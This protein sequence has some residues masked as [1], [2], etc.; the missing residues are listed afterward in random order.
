VRWVT[1]LLVLALVAGGVAAYRLDL[2]VPWYD[3]FFGDEPAAP[4]AESPVEVPPP[5]ALDL[6]PV[7]ATVP[8]AEVLGTSG[9]AAPAQVEAALAPYLAD[10]DLGPHVLAAVA[11]RATGR[12]LARIGSGDAIPASTTKLL[13]GLAA[14][15]ALGPERTFSTRV[16]AGGRGRV[17][18]VGGGDPFLMAE[19]VG[20]DGPSYPARADVVTLADKTAA[21]LRRQGRTKVRLGFDDSLFADPGFNPA[22]P[23]SY[24]E[25]G[26][27]VSPITALWV[28]Q[29]REPD[30]FRRVED[31][32]L[33]GAQVFAA[34]LVEAG[35]T[36]VGDPVHGVAGGSGREIASVTSAPVREIVERVVEVSDNEAAEVLAHHIG[37]E[38]RGAGSFSAGVEGT[39]RTL[40]A[41]GVPTDG[42][43]IYD[44]SGLSRD[45][46]ITPDALLAVLRIAATGEP[47]LRTLVG[48]LP[49]SAFTG[50]LADRFDEALPETRGLVRAKTGT[51]TAVSSLAGVVVDQQGHQMVF[52]LMADR[53]RK[54]R[55]TAAEDAL[56]E[57]AAALAG[58][59]CGKVSP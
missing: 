39:V 54:P 50:S 28:D 1:A 17:V 8:V 10:A 51:L 42:I 21:A 45:N 14:L 46:R 6:P 2:V 43:E 48:A 59:F 22:W 16:V 32:S 53:I 36:V 4:L 19:P 27:I 11:D 24:A 13:T 23:A 37:L 7:P 29:G 38:V 40:R 56:D 35:I 9:R 15:Q 20:A 57:A 44:G 26:D 49:V 18:L 41:L 25:E 47:M 33:R 30:S 34:A 5:P 12:P 31:P 52:V 3:H 58:C 55:E